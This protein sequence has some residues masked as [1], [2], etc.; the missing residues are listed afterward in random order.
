MGPAGTAK[1]TKGPQ[2]GVQTRVLGP[3]DPRLMQPGCEASITQRPCSSGCIWGPRCSG[4]KPGSHVVQPGAQ[5]GSAET[6]HAPQPGLPAHGVSRAPSVLVSVTGAPERV[7]AHPDR[8]S[9]GWRDALPRSQ[10]TGQQ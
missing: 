8:L 2:V 1:D 3:P 5:P 6:V 10:V 9:K 4:N 7:P